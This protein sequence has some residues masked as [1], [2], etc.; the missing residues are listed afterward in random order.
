VEI[1]Q[2]SK[3]KALI[4]MKKEMIKLLL[5]EKSTEFQ[6]NDLNNLV[7]ELSQ[8]NPNETNLDT[9]I[10]QDFEKVRKYIKKTTTESY[11]KSKNYP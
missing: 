10:A 1:K 8:V 9:I 4:S 5:D 3:E 6:I 7:T 2:N 11:N